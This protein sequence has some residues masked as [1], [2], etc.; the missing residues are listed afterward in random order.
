MIS[1]YD[2]NI[3]F[4]CSYHS[5]G[6]NIYVEE[7]A[8]KY[9][10]S[11]QIWLA[12]STNEQVTRTLT[13]TIE[14]LQ[15][16]IG[17]ATRGEVARII[18]VARHVFV[19]LGRIEEDYASIKVI[20]SC[21]E[22]LKKWVT[23][24]IHDSESSVAGRILRLRHPEAIP[25]PLKLLTVASN[26][27]ELDLVKNLVERKYGREICTF[28]TDESAKLYKDSADVVNRDRLL[29]MVQ[30]ADA[31][32]CR[33][34]EVEEPKKQLTCSALPPAPP[35]LPQTP[36][37]CVANDMEEESDGDGA[38]SCTMSSSVS[39][40][41]EALSARRNT[42]TSY[43]AKNDIEE[44]KPLPDSDRPREMVEVLADAFAK[45]FIHANPQ[46]KVDDSDCWG[47]DE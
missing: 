17:Q 13:V 26:E 21:A 35:S 38:R 24:M 5:T 25:N 2:H 30:L 22:G 43:E 31:C 46:D 14:T 15:E 40:S 9:C 7:G 8:L 18:E 1:S 27:F 34:N 20:K 32:Q 28:V 19:G 45:K 47:D 6:C 39:I 11:P 36:L 42:L 37:T 12:G 33:I 29:L 16:R 23:D 10:K 3:Y 44:D 41:A 4:I